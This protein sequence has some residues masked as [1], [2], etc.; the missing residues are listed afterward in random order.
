MEKYT[1]FECIFIEINLNKKKWLIVGTYNPCNSMIKNHVYLLSSFI[2][3]L[4]VEYKN[5]IIMG[6][7][8]A[9]PE[10]MELIYFYNSYCLKSLKNEPTC[11]KNINNPESSFLLIVVAL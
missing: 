5:F 6:D 3:V 8:N 2:D 4:S 9:E 11:Y 10:A 1:D 7:F